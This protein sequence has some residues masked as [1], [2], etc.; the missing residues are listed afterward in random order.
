MKSLD[1]DRIALSKR[2]T[3]NL[4]EDPIRRFA[5]LF[6]RACRA[7]VPQPEAM[8]LA[9]ADRQGRVS[10]R[11]VL[12][13][14]VDQRGFVFYTDLRSLKGRQLR[15]NPHAALVF[16][17]QPL[18]VQVRVEGTVELVSDEEADAYWATRPRESRIGASVSRQSHPL[19]SR[20]LLL[21]EFRNAREKFKGKDVPRPPYWSGF[22]V[23]PE[24]IE[25]WSYRSY[26]LHHRELYLKNRGKRGGW[27]KM[28]LY[29]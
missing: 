19:S 12:L 3:S 26:R 11:F 28:L 2:A 29:P 15:Q 16:Y 25:F 7:Q 14:S 9:T 27:S 21:N 18:R 20:E 23:V 5:N 24:R 22:R 17:W 6:A 13:K 4:T 8:A 10:V 1:L